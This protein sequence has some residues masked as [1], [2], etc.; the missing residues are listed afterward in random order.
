MNGK[1][2]QTRPRRNILRKCDEVM[3]FQRAG[4][5]DLMYVKMK[6][7]G[8]KE[9]HGI[10]NT[11]IEDSKGNIVVDTGQALKIWENYSTEFED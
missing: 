11:G 10:Q 3:E 6:E 5:Y 9:S 7:L 2:P 4:R 8:W 1:E